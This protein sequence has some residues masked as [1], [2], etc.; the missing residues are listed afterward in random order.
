MQDDIFIVLQI[1]IQARYWLTTRMKKVLTSLK[2]FSQR[3]REAKQ[4]YIFLQWLFM[5]WLI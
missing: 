5:S 3:L 2:N 4:K 1:L